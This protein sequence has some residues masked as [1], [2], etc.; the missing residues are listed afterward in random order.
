MSRAFIA[1][2]SNLDHPLEQLHCAVNALRSNRNCRVDAVSP[3][4]RSTAVGPGTQPD[5]INGVMAL[6]TELEP[7]PLLDLL[8]AQENAQGRVRA[9]RWGAR[10][11]DLDL[12]IYDQ[13]Q[14]TLP[15]LQLPHPRLAQR[16]FVLY[17]LHDIAPGLTLPSGTSIASLLAQTTAEGL[18]RLGC[19]EQEN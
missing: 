4:Y 9:Q 7:I 17:P 6:S 12:L 2:G 11:L 14:L 19:K 8:Q 1:L 18:T 13:Q 16:N 15:R 5:Y 10:T 3:W